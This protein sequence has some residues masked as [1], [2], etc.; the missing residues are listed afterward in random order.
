MGCAFKATDVGTAAQSLSHILNFSILFFFCCRLFRLLVLPLNTTRW[1]PSQSCWGPPP[2][3]YGTV[4]ASWSLNWWVA[5][6]ISKVVSCIHIL[7]LG[8]RC[9]RLLKLLL[10][11]CA[12]SFLPICFC[13]CVCMNVCMYIYIYI[14]IYIKTST[15]Y[16]L[17]EL[18]CS[19]V[20]ESVTT[21]HNAQLHNAILKKCIALSFM[22]V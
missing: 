17:I 16:V 15:A 6:F 4:C 7:W 20:C 22:T 11:C 13:V 5:V 9:A 1:M 8:V 2:T 14:Y 18:S 3:S 19:T 10:K 12:Y 21:L